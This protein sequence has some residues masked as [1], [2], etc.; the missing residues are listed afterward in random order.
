MA[1]DNETL[2]TAIKAAITSYAGQPGSVTANGRT[3][4]YRTL[5]ELTDAMESLERT[6]TSGPIR[7]KVKFGFFR[8]GG[9]KSEL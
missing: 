9:I 8:P 6:D 2:I 4:I 7:S 3:V 1:N 5:K